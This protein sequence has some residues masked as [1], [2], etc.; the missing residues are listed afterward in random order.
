ML[1]STTALAARDPRESFLNIWRS[2]SLRNATSVP[3]L[4]RPPLT[5]SASAKYNAQITFGQVS[6]AESFCKE[7]LLFASHI[8]GS[9]ESNH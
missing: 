8:V 2:N 6:R 7:F 5:G 3:D 1:S 4:S 9:L